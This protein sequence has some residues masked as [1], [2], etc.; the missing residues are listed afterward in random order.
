MSLSFRRYP[1]R[2]AVVIPRSR[3]GRRALGVVVTVLVLALVTPV[4]WVQI[5]G[6]TRVRPSADAIE[7]VDAV[8]VLGAGLRADGTPSTY[9]RRRLDAAAELYAAGAAP[10][11]IVS[12]DAH[13]VDDGTI[14]DEPGSMRDWILDKGVPNDALV[15]DRRGFDTTRSCRRAQEE[16]GVTTAVVVTQDYHLRRALFSCGRAGLDAVGVGV[17][18]QSVTPVQAAWWHVREI[19]ASWNAAFGELPESWRELPQS[20]LDGLREL[21]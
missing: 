20:W 15:L 13:L 10:V 18:A 4:A 2:H 3:A 14:Y 1:P 12:G 5:T 17:S 21:V 16:Y 7:P 11:V 8:L 19:P 6:Q 9:L